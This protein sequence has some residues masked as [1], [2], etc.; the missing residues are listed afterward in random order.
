MTDAQI[1]YLLIR[2]DPI[3][4]KADRAAEHAEA[5]RALETPVSK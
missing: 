3:S 5:L 4:G 1:H 2:A